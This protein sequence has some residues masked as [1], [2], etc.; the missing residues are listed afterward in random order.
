MAE[1]FTARGLPVPRERFEAVVHHY[2][3]IG[4]RSPL[5]ELTARQADGLRALTRHATSGTGARPPGTESEA[6]ATPKP[7]QQ[8]V[9]SETPPQPVA[10]KEFRKRMPRPGGLGKPGARGRRMW[11]QRPGRIAAGVENRHLSGGPEPF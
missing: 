10:A 11:R 1:Y 4:G 5:N 9:A 3:V 2:E 7:A 8:A 6:T